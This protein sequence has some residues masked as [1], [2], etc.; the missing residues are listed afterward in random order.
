MNKTYQEKKPKFSIIVPIY[1]VEE[2]L[3]QCI[4]SVLNQNYESFQLIL[5]DDESPDNC[6]TICDDFAKKDVRIKVIHQKNK[7][8][9]G[10][11]NSGIDN[12]EGEY[13]VFLD[14]DDRL[15][16]NSLQEF[17][18]ILEKKNYD[19]V[20]GAY[21]TEKSTSKTIDKIVEADIEIINNK[22][23]ALEYSL[24]ETKKVVWE[25]CAKAFKRS[26]FSENGLYFR[27]G[28]IGAE[29]C[30]FFVR[31]IKL[32]KSV[33]FTNQYI[34][35][36]NNMRDGSITTNKTFKSVKGEL[37]VFYKHYNDFKSTLPKVSSYFGEKYLMIILAIEII[38]NKEQK[39]QLYKIARENYLAFDMCFTSKMKII[40]PFLKIGG[41][42]LTSKIVWHLY[43]KYRKRAPK[44][45][46]KD[47]K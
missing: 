41:I 47:N 31:V 30:E 19:L 35:I 40:Y 8:L 42:K 16:E 26:I 11:R 13:I 45:F 15:Y 36:Y 12:A 7:G 34:F 20:I 14:G 38:K 3:T 9:S 37:E 46:L 39:N 17:A 32:F 5:V 4:F 28:L 18:N 23:E 1:K 43:F 22:N 21:V 27:E 24:F 44:K 25:A 2:W 10:A 29:D 33:Y 6:P